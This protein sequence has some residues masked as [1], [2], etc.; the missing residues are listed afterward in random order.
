MVKMSI[1]GT[2]QPPDGP[3]RLRRLVELLLGPEIE[4]G[5]AHTGQEDQRLSPTPDCSGEKHV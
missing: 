2:R 3:Q 1:T 5:A 4:K